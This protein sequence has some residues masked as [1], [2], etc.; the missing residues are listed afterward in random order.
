MEINVMEYLNEQEI[1]EIVQDELRISI[2]HHFNECG[3]LEADNNL[4]RLIGNASYD[5]VSKMV[6]NIFGNNIENLLTKRVT[7]IIE[8]GLTEYSIF[9][10]PDAW[11]KTPNAAY[12]IL[13]NAVKS[14]HD[15]MK[16]F[17]SDNI[18]KQTLIELKRILNDDG[19]VDIIAE[20]YKEI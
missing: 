19:I 8:K 12:V 4:K 6:D 2:R 14:Q 1:K 11:D 17:I 16:Q 15:K 20:I 13:E 3:E 10:K 7:K 18:E 9:K 5:V